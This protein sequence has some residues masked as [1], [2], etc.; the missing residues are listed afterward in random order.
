MKKLLYPVQL[1]ESSFRVQQLHLALAALGLPVPDAERMER[2]A[3]EATVKAVRDLQQRLGITSDDRVVLDAATA[4]AFEKELKARGILND[5]CTFTVSG[6]VVAANND[7]V[8][9]VSLL[10]FDIDL[11]GAAIY[12]KVKTVEEIYTNGGFEL[13]GETHAA[14]DGYYSFTFYCEQFKNAERKKADVVVYAVREKE[15]LG[16]SRL[17]NAADYSDTGEVR[18]LDVVIS[19]GDNRTEYEKL[20][21]PLSRFL[22]ESRVS[23]AEI[24]SSSQQVSFTAGEL[25]AD[26]L[27]VAVAAAAEKM[28]RDNKLQLSH[29]LLYALG[30]FNY[31]LSLPAFAGKTEAALQA[32]IA[33]AAAA[34]IIREY[35]RKEV[36]TFIRE[37]LAAAEQAALSHKPAGNSTALEEVLSLS[38]PEKEQQTAFLAALRTFK[39]E[40][41]REFWNSHLPAQPQFK[42][43]PALIEGLLLTQQLTYITGNH[44][45]L[46]SELQQSKKIKTATDLLNLSD[47]DWKKIIK[48]TGVPAIVAGANDEEKINNYA[49]GLQ[50]VLYAAFPTQKIG[51]MLDSKELATSDSKVAAGMQAFLQKNASFNIAQSRVYDFDKEIKAAAG[52]NAEAVKSDLMKLQRIFQVSPSPEAMPVLLK[53]GLD[54]ARAIAS[55]P[56]KSFIKMYSAELGGEEMAYAVHQRASY[57]NTRSEV[58][59]LHMM[60]ASHSATPAFAMHTQQHKAVMTTL[61]NQVPNYAELF[62]SPDICECK[63]C[64]SVYGAAAYFVDLL[65]FLWRGVTNADNKTPLDMLT[66]RR[67]D[68]LYLPLTCENTETLIPYVDLVNEIME[69]YTVNG[70]LNTFKGYDTGEITPQ[71]LR[72]DPQ[73]FNVN[74]YKSHLKDAKYPFSLP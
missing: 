5:D 61:Q 40:D 16:R 3:G 65:R 10:A 4:A 74:A 48:K 2:K 6:K 62:G 20:M 37:L 26:Q 35:D 54:S 13:L 68:L 28:N 64:R 51:K 73:N 30:R 14:K 59:A 50:Q 39:G 70:S 53:H 18:N 12:N 41:Y 69:H 72:A 29:E 56:Q 9:R 52:D 66:K 34:T 38:L 55:V 63:H 11:R 46:M 21:G 1:N 8:N 36:L 47:K 71:E 32:A 49:A 7:S 42:E 15:I 58:T 19:K 17:V 23:L 25:D 60:E 22:E 67:P 43:K 31:R 27:Q 44:Q 24:A 45:P 57:I 33:D